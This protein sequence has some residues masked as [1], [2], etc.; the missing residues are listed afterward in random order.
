MCKRVHLSLHYFSNKGWL[1]I[2]F[3]IKSQILDH[4]CTTLGC[5]RAGEIKQI[6]IILI[7]VSPAL[8]H[9]K[10][11]PVPQTVKHLPTMQ[12]NQ[13]QSLGREDPLEKEMATH[14]SI[15]A[16]KIPWL[17]ERGR[18]QSVPWGCKESDM[19]AIS[20]HFTMWVKYNM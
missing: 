18:L 15:R 13:V 19:T 7:P 5:E 9:P 4:L 8:S 6:K 16:W 17:E 12:E 2:F 10:G 14:S 3:G 20:L 11:S 1:K